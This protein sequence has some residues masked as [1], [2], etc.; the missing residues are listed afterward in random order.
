MTSYYCSDRFYETL[1]ESIQNVIISTLFF[2]HTN[3]EHIHVTCSSNASICICTKN[4][5]IG[6]KLF[7]QKKIKRITRKNV[8]SETLISIS[9]NISG[10]EVRSVLEKLR[11]DRVNI[12]SVIWDCTQYLSNTQAVH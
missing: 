4:I 5:Q 10:L 1:I 7:F 2:F 6:S 11:D 9:A 12:S 3:G 8:K